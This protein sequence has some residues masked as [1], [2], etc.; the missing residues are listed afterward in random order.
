MNKNMSMS[1]RRILTNHI[2]D[3]LMSYTES[4]GDDIRP[5]NAQMRL[6]I[7]D[8]LQKY[9]SRAIARLDGI[10]DASPNGMTATHRSKQNSTDDDDDDSLMY[11][12]AEPANDNART[13]VKRMS[14]QKMDMNLSSGS[15][16]PESLLKPIDQRPKLDGKPVSP[17]QQIDEKQPPQVNQARNKLRQAL[18]KAIDE[19]NGKKQKIE[20]LQ[21]RI[22]TDSPDMVSHVP[23]PN[24]ITAISSASNSSSEDMAAVKDE[25]TVYDLGQE[26]FLKLFSLGTPAFVNYLQNRRPQRKKRN[27]TSTERNDFHYGKY[28]LYERQ[29]AKNRSKR[30]FL[31]SPPATRAKRR[32]ASNAEKPEIVV[33]EKKDYSR[34]KVV[35]AATVKT[36]PS[37]TIVSNNKR[38]CLICWKQSEFRN[39]IFKF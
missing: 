33:P 30:A 25:E 22:T 20:D 1:E 15:G 7:T 6:G 17:P 13:A 26:R 23:S 3:E 9:S 14:I 29:F 4:V 21:I 8:L 28:E 16:K 12:D 34:N 24:S 32:T 35:T 5:K 18:F 31:Y 37:A 39:S 38:V 19:S 2:R 11:V 27:C 36:N 10:D